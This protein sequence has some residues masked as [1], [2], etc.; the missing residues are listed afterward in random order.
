MSN[1]VGD[2]RSPLRAAI[3]EATELA[4][5]KYGPR[6]LKTSIAAGAFATVF[7]GAITDELIEEAI[8]A[9]RNAPPKTKSSFNQ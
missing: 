1:D 9:A 6:G 3:R 4:Y 2:I 5:M 8:A 7:L